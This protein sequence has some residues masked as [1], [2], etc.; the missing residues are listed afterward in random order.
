MTIKI[1]VL[2]SIC[3][4]KIKS[5]LIHC[6]KRTECWCK[7]MIICFSLSII[8][9]TVVDLLKMSVVYAVCHVKDRTEELST[10]LVILRQF[11]MLPCGLEHCLL[12]LGRFQSN[13]LH[14]SSGQ[15]TSTLCVILHSK[16]PVQAWAF[17]S[18]CHKIVCTRALKCSHMLQQGPKSSLP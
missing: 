4:Y 7:F 1:W 14:S 6:C 12:L 10:I 18:F 5:W 17:V 2:S 13:L 16:L 11:R 3:N 15:K 8:K 9:C